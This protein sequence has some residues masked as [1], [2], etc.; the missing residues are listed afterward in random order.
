MYTGHRTDSIKIF[1]GFFQ[2]TIVS[3]LY[4]PSQF[5]LGVKEPYPFLS[6]SIIYTRE[7]LENALDSTVTRYGDPSNRCH[8]R[9]DILGERYIPCKMM[10]AVLTHPLF[11]V[12]TQYVQSFLKPW[13]VVI[14]E[15]NTSF[16]Y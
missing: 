12:K 11:T 14:K 15:T 7:V 5:Q 16:P 1:V 13:N 9:Y 2:R 4:T 3:R 8:H 10:P 6:Y